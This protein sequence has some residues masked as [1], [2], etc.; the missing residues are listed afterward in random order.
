[1]KL[2]FAAAVLWIAS[3]GVACAD[4]ALIEAAK[5]NDHDAAVAL[6][7]KGADVREREVDGTTAL[8][9]AIH[10]GD[11]D[12]VQ[13][14]VKA[15][16][17]VS[18]ANDY[19]ATPLSEAAI[20]GDTAILKSLLRAG[21]DADSP[22]AE[23]Q[24]AL[25]A[26]ARTGNVESAKLLL[27]HGARIDATERWG[28]QTALM[29]AAAQSQP[30][31]VKFLI[32]HGANVDTRGAVR[33]WQ[34]RVTAEGR[35]KNMN[36]GGLT[37]LLYAAREGCIECAKHLTKGGANLDLADPDGAT[38]LLLALLNMRFDLSAYLI[39][40]GADVNKWDFYGQTPLYTAID[41]HTLPVGGRPDLPSVDDKNG[42]QIAEMLL[43]AGAN[44]NAQLKLRPRY[45][46]G[47]FDR[48]GDQVLSTGATPL[49]LAAK[50]G[51]AAAITL[52]LKYKALVNL[53]TATGVTPLMAAAGMGH[54]FNPTRGRFKTD[55]QAVECLRLLREAG[56]EINSSGENGLT[57][58][59]AAAA[60]GWNGTVEALAAAGANLEATDRKGLAPIDYAAGRHE[61]AFLEPEHKK[62]DSTITLLRERILA[63][64][65]REPKEFNG[66]LNRQTRGTG[67]AVSE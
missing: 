21:A 67:A 39:T 19:G 55:E 53:P 38:P 43:E 36:R 10:N 35:P 17:D 7:A 23:G 5:A 20:L 9:W 40:A 60:H 50:T 41:M 11:L 44:P 24:T 26:V 33:D 22:N 47:V 54:S 25:M 66:T 13:R 51:D 32:S 46:N 28:G 65:G 52:L 58:L 56:G 37:P 4:P 18:A 59:H 64:T 62:Y 45:R 8:H 16:A 61:R 6:I 27:K 48:G 3:V 29:W 15:R 34:R 49:L 63:A 31:M 30:E 14:L 57:A 42:L 12:L 1:M 2:W